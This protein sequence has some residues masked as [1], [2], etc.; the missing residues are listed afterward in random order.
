MT[1]M[2]LL[3]MVYHIRVWQSLNAQE[4]EENEKGSAMTIS[5]LE[6]DKA[7]QVI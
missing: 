7:A 4:V 1:P 6:K 5:N 2:N 3:N